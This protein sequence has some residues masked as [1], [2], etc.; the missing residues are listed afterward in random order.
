MSDRRS[1]N[2]VPKHTSWG[3]LWLAT[4]FALFVGLAIGF[5]IGALS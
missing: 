2:L 3:V 5:S 1:N 4:L